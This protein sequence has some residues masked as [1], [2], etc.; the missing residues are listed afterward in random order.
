MRWLTY[1]RE[2]E[3]RLLVIQIYAEGETERN[4]AKD[5]IPGRVRK[6]LSDWEGVT[7][8]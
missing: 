8:E 2:G 5:K 7:H 6:P 1:H 3:E 4:V